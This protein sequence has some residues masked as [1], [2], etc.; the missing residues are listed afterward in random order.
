MTYTIKADNGYLD[1]EMEA[2]SPEEIR[3]Y[4]YKTMRS[5]LSQTVYADVK[6]ITVY[7]ESGAPV[8]SLFSTSHDPGDAEPA[9]NYSA[10]LFAQV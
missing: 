10:G 4:I 2:E 5:A 9:W 3:I 8:L 1:M 6:T 7:D